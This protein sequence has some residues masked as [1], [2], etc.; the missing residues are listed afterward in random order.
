ML[1]PSF[2][3]VLCALAPACKESAPPPPATTAAPAAPPAPAAHTKWGV[4][5]GRIQLS[6]TPP[7][8]AR[9]PTIGT[10][11]SVCGEETEERS[12][13]VG[14]EGGVA[15]AVVSLKD[16]K[17]LPAPVRPAP[18]PVLDQKQCVYDP[19]VLAAKTGSTLVIRNSDPLVHN[20]RAASGTN[21]AFF[22]VAMPLEGM[23]VRRQLPAEPGEVPIHCDIHPWMRAR[24][25]TF[26]HGY[27]ATSGADGRFRLEVPEGTHTVVVWHERLPEQLHTVTVRTGE[28]VQVDAR[29][30]T[31]DLK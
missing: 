16:G 15:H 24:V 29:W 13:V 28:T 27:F 18:E 7:T 9:Q 26:D 23:S 2:I 8:P 14:A 4:I 17:A 6:G 19:P 31:T 12:L 3:L 30:A 1:R 10:V 21:R 20:V 5:E 25:R 22:N 11:V